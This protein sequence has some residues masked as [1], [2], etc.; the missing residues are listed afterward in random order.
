MAHCL[1][2]FVCKDQENLVTLFDKGYYYSVEN[3]YAIIG[4]CYENP[5]FIN[6]H[7]TL[8]NKETLI[9]ELKSLGI[10]NCISIHT[11]Y[12]YNDTQNSVF[13]DFISQPKKLKT[14]N[15]GLALLGVRKSQTEIDLFDSI[16]LGHYRSERDLMPEHYAQFIQNEKARIEN[17]RL[18]AIYIEWI[19]E[20]GQLT[21]L[22]LNLKTLDLVYN[23]VSSNSYH[24]ERKEQKFYTDGLKCH[25]KKEQEKS[26]KTNS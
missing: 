18:E 7:K 19:K 17:E 12:G 5:K 26:L 10:S 25:L 22:E 13:Y 3:G 21:L 24:D 2:A 6:G 14:I 8:V 23:G 15:E 11:D 4:I 9:S 1:S 20:F 16:N